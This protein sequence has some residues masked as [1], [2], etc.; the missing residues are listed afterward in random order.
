MIALGGGVTSA[1]L[2][3]AALS[4]A[5]DKALEDVPEYTRKPTTFQ[6]AKKDYGTDVGYMQSRNFDSA[7]V[8]PKQ[9][10]TKAYDNTSSEK[11]KILLRRAKEHGLVITGE[12]YRRPGI[13]EHEIGHAIAKNT[14]TPWEKFTQG[15]AA[16]VLGTLAGIAGLGAGLHAGRKWGP[17]AGG[18]AGLGISGL[19]NIPNIHGEMIANQYAKE[20]LP[21]GTKSVS[22][23]PFLGS[24]VNAGVTAPTVAGA[25]AGLLGHK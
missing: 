18:L 7:M 22:T 19:G 11:L 14:G 23:W 5:G 1:L 20:L 6:A 15:R 12:G 17:V 4:H 9:D 8:V 10:I 16:P 21:E 13:V 24:Y 2:T 3:G 25:L